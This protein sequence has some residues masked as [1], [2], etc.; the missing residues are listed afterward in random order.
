MGKL[1][2]EPSELKLLLTN[3]VERKATETTLTRLGLAP[4][5]TCWVADRLGYAG[6]ASVFMALEEA[7]EQGRL[8]AGDLLALCTS[9]AGFIL[10]TAVFRW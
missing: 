3:Q 10:A 9:G 5:H 6:S 8:A 1:E 7:L 4:N 2:I